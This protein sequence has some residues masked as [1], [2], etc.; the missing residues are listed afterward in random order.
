MKFL[1]FLFSGF[2]IA[3]SNRAL[4]QSQCSSTSN[5]TTNPISILTNATSS[6]VQLVTG[7]VSSIESIVFGI[8]GLIFSGVLPR[9]LWNSIQIIN[10]Y[11]MW[12]LV[13]N[14]SCIEY[15]SVHT[16]DHCLS[17]GLNNKYYPLFC[18]VNYLNIFRNVEFTFDI[19]S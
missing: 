18:F 14:Y 13:Q 19:L 3:C 7:L 1:L 15:R 6:I 16:S 5:S 10:L 2:L 12:F 17:V 9:K 4:A 11:L 8:F